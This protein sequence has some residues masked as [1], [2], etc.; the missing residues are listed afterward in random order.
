[1]SQKFN[2]PVG[3][4]PVEAYDVQTGVVRGDSKLRELNEETVEREVRLE[5]G[6]RMKVVG[7]DIS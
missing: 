1:M 4:R 6:V 7:E 2:L 3:R 5:G